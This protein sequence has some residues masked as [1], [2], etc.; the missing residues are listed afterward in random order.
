LLKT[1]AFLYKDEDQ[2]G[3]W[4]INQN[5]VSEILQFIGN[6]AFFETICLAGRM[7]WWNSGFLEDWV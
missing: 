1:T 4:P 5:Y 2:V 7:E 3:A 6:T